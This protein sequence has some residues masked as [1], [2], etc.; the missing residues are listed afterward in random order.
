MPVWIPGVGGFAVLA[1]AGRWSGVA[2]VMC[3]P[4]LMNLVGARGGVSAVVAAAEHLIVAQ[5]ST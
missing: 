4:A 1:V 2:A 3:R 5:C